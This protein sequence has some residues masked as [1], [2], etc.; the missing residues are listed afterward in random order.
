[1][2]KRD[3]LNCAASGTVTFSFRC[4]VGWDEMEPTE[5]PRQRHCREC[6]RAVYWCH[7]ANEAGIRADQ[8]EC[9]AVPVWLAE[10]ARKRVQPERLVIAG[11][12]TRRDLLAEVARDYVAADEP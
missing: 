6:Q 8:G 5:D 4:P 7:D 9:I 12:V 10:G 1:M 3:I 11:R 2:G